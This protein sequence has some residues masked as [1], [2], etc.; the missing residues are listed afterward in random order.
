MVPL[1]SAV[2]EDQIEAKF[3][4]GVLKVSIPK[5]EEAKTRHIEVKS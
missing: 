3:G 2:V 1:P 4:D 5:G